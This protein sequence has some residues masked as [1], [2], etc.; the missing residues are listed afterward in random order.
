MT[1]QRFGEEKNELENTSDVKHSEPKTG[2][3]R[4]SVVTVN[5]TAEYVELVMGDKNMT[6]ICYMIDH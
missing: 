2:T 3:H 6:S 4:L 5:L 1:K